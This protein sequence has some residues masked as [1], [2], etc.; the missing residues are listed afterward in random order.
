MSKFLLTLLGIL[1]AINFIV[2]PVS[3]A[4]PNILPEGAT[5][6]P[7]VGTDNNTPTQKGVKD[8]QLTKTILPR[9][10]K[11]L[12][13]FGAGMAVLSIVIGGVMILT[14]AGD[15]EMNTK[16]VK[17]IILAIAGLLIMMLAY[18]IVSIIENLTIFKPPSL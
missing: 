4:I 11:W 12:M 15:T 8:H 5:D 18:A 16:G 7:L 1:F 9:L 6:V 17:V 3:A 13:G 14:S 10:I 2:I